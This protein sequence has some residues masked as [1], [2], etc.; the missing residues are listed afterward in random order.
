MRAFNRYTFRTDVRIEYK[1]E[2]FAGLSRN[3][4]QGGMFIEIAKEFSIGTVLQVKFNLPTHNEP[5]VTQAQVRW[6][7]RKEGSVT[8]MG[9]QF[10]RLK[11]IEI[12]AINQ[13]GK[14]S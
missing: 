11:P 6:V 14:N 9:V 3:I 5:I 7:E 10:L 1:G 4:S 13:L 12:W 2:K 8:G